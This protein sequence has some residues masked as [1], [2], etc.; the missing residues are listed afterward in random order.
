MSRNRIDTHHHVLPT[1]WL[2]WLGSVSPAPGFAYPDWTPESAIAAMDETETQTAILS[3]SSPGVHLGDDAQARDMARRVNEYEAEQVKQR[4]DRFGFF[5][6][7]PVPDID[8]SIKEAEYALDTLHADG[9]ILIAQTRGVYVGD[10]SLDPL[11]DYLNRRGAVVFI[12]PDALPGPASS[13]PPFLADFLLDTARAA[14]SMVLHDIPRRF[15]GVKVILSHG[16]GFLPYIPARLE[17][18]LPA[19]GVDGA[20]AVA[21]LKTFWYDT[22]LTPSATSL[23]SLLGFADHSRILY[24]SDFPYATPT[25]IGR[26][27]HTL[28]TA[29]LDDALRRAVDHGNAESIL[30]RFTR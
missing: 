9:V 7:L 1:F 16:G 10:R 21:Q 3:V 25:A 15:P 14:L 12:H 18:V 4:P 28:E 6:S 24:G 29:G 2:D 22:A 23:P 19:M 26:F 13:V 8:G 5:A 20:D 11:M 30:P 17:A 27:A